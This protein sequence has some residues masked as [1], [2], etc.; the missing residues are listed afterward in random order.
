MQL[1]HHN[2]ISS[3]ILQFHQSKLRYSDTTISIVVVLEGS[4]DV[5]RLN[6]ISSNIFTSTGI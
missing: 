5:K 6:K 3:N 4:V 1:N 2:F